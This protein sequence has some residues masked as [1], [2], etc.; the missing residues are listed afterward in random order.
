M[1]S[2]FAFM[3][4][5]PSAT[6]RRRKAQLIASFV[7]GL[8]SEF[9]SRGPCGRVSA[10]RFDDFP[11]SRRQVDDPVI[12]LPLGLPGRKDDAAGVGVEESNLN[13]AD[14]LRRAPVSQPNS[15]RSRKFG[16]RTASMMTAYSA[17]RT[18]TSLASRAASSPWRSDSARSSPR[19]MPS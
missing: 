11:G 7:H 1:A 14:F 4:R 16:S 5:R 15:I 19:Q 10:S 12:L 2:P 9:S 18:A 3:I 17:G 8:P 6:R 13:F